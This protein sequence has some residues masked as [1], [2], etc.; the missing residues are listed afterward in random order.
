VAFVL[1][2]D[3]VG[4]FGPD[5]ADEPFGVAVGS[6]CPRGILTVVMPSEANTAS[7]DAPYLV[8]RS[9]MRN[10]KRGSSVVEVGHEVAG[11]LGGPRHRRV[12]GDAETNALTSVRRRRRID[13]G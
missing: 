8:S 6:W 12:R 10:R 2:E 9:R 11:G 4:A 3:P 5:A 7:N 13:L 1:D